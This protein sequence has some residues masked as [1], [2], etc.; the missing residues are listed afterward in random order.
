M[1]VAIKPPPSAQLVQQQPPRH[2][3]GAQTSRW[4]RRQRVPAGSQWHWPSGKSHPGSRTHGAFGS[5]S[6]EDAWGWRGGKT[7]GEK[8][9]DR[10]V[11]AGAEP[12]TEHSIRSHITTV[13]DGL[14]WRRRRTTTPVCPPPA[15]T[16]SKAPAIGATIFGIL[17][18]GHAS[19][20]SVYKCGKVAAGRT[21]P[22]PLPPFWVIVVSVCA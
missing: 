10:D 4:S 15:L 21:F 8:V 9:V 22:F 2:P 11:A 17:A 13:A 12:I 5:P 16:Q 14:G 20:L 19:K 6:N 1:A 7:G 3:E 18:N